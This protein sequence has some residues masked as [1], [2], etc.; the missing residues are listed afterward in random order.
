MEKI[1]K[2]FSPGSKKDDEVMY[3]DPET[4]RQESLSNTSGQEPPKLYPVDGASGQKESGGVLG[5]I[6]NPGGNKYDEQRY[7]T[8]A[9]SNPDPNKLHTDPSAKKDHSVMNQILNPGGECHVCGMTK[10]KVVLMQ[11][12]RPQV[13]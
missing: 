7:G 9:T 2:V 13:R 1:K 4:R 6:T 10:T 5:Q 12:V 8:T 11:F 3:G